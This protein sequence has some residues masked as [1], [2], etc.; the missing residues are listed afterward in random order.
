M[1]NFKEKELMVEKMLTGV[2]LIVVILIST[3]LIGLFLA[4]PIMW[5]WNHVMPYLFSFKTISWSQACCLNFLAGSL[6]QSSLRHN[7]NK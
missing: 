7:S 3:A 2:G 4:F 1:N 5:T 6:I